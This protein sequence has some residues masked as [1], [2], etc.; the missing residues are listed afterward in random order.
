[1]GPGVRRGDGE[2]VHLQTTKASPLLVMPPMFLLAADTNM[3]VPASND[4]GIVEALTA[5]KN[6]PSP[7]TAA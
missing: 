2:S 7:L 5:R 4:H 6:E 3:L 1:M